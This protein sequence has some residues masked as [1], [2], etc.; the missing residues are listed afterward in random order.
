MLVFTGLSRYASKIAEEQV[1]NTKKK[2]KELTAMHELV[3]NAINVLNSKVDITQ[4]GKLLHKSWELK[5]RISDKISNGM[6][7]N[8]YDC[9]VRNGALGGKL[10][11]AGGG[12]FMVFFVTPEN[13]KKVREGLK[14]LLEVKFDFENDG[15]QIIYYAPQET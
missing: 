14:E 13:R 15:S 2:K 5:K 12:G 8:L 3:D 10:L 6:I 4:F 11:G 1:K 9:A 7:D